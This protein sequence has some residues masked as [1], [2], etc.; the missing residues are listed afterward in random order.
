MSAP[1]RRIETLPYETR[2]KLQAGVIRQLAQ[3]Q[4]EITGIIKEIVADTSA[5]DFNYDDHDAITFE[6]GHTNFQYLT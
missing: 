2:R 4:H 3:L 5:V 6:V 1:V